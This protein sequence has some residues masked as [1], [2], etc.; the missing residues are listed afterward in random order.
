[1]TI[2]FKKILPQKTPNKAFLVKKTKSGTFCPKFT[3]FCFFRQILQL[4]KFEGADFKYDNSILFI[5]IVE[6]TEIK[7]FLSEV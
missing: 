5:I 2:V 4:K 3:H 7:Y 6:M 1:M